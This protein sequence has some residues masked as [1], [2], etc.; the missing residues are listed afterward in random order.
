M[1]TFLDSHF[2]IQQIE[3]RLNRNQYLSN[4][5][6]PNFIDA[7]VLKALKTSDSNFLSIL[8]IPKREIYPNFY[9]WY[10]LMRQFA[11]RTLQMWIKN[12]EFEHLNDSIIS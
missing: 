8:E 11:D 1:P 6:L 9:H 12:H 5:C 10:V 2:K 7:Q 3:S 4:Q